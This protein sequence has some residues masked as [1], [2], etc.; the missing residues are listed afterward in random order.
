MG[1]VLNINFKYLLFALFCIFI[2]RKPDDTSL[3]QDYSAYCDYIIIKQEISWEFNSWRKNEAGRSWG[4]QDT[5]VAYTNPLFDAIW[6]PWWSRF[7]KVMVE[8]ACWL[9]T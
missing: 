2:C 1:S 6:S 8:K 9:S 4:C 3:S 5:I 7:K